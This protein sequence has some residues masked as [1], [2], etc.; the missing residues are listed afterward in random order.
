MYALKFKEYKRVPRG[1][2]IRNSNIREEKPIIKSH[3][4]Q[5]ILIDIFKEYEELNRND[6]TIT[7]K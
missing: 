1:T 3:K 4:I 6:I 2:T 7:T 5:I